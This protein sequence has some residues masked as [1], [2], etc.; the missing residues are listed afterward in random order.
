MYFNYFS[1]VFTFASLFLYTLYSSVLSIPI[2]SRNN[3][4]T[5]CTIHYT[6][7]S[8]LFCRHLSFPFPT[9]PVP[10]GNSPHAMYHRAGW[11]LLDLY[12]IPLKSPMMYL[13]IRK[14]G[15]VRFHTVPCNFFFIILE[16]SSDCQH[17]LVICI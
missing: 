11:L 15:T 16:D 14:K 8:F 6:T 17:L 3:I 12:T 10:T 13:H 5:N 7:Y 2:S 9:A 4:L 1:I